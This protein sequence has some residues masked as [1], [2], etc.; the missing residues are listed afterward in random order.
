MAL[1]NADGKSPGGLACGSFGL[2]SRG[3]VLIHLNR[4][5]PPCNLG[6]VLGCV[7]HTASENPSPVAVCVTATGAAA[8][9]STTLPLLREALGAD[10]PEV[11]LRLFAGLCRRLSLQAGDMLY[12]E[13]E[14]LGEM[15]VVDEGEVHLVAHGST[16]NTVRRAAVLGHEALLTEPPPGAVRTASAVAATDAVV[17]VAHGSQVSDTPPSART[18]PFPAVWTAL[19]RRNRRSS[20]RFWYKVFPE[21][22]LE[23]VLMVDARAPV[24][25]S[26]GSILNHTLAHEAALLQHS[27]GAPLLNPPLKH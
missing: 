7:S 11:A 23:E 4:K 20:H 9:A 5:R 25:C 22:P 14:S 15:F 16:V 12:A 2:V 21:E 8:A 10:V 17:L 1:L 24:R 3:S 18:I 6:S 27:T 13:G 19:S 26:N